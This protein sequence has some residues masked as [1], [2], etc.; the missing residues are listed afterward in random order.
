LY[1][2][3]AMT[4]ELL[5]IG[6]LSRRTGVAPELLRAWERRYGLLEPGRTPGR[7][8]LYSEADVAR[9]GSM[10]AHLDAG[11]SASEAARA[12][13]AERSRV[14]LPLLQEGAD[15]LAHALERFDDDG[16]QAALDRLLAGLSL[17]VVVREV[18]VPYLHEVGERWAR[19][20]LSVGQEHFISNVI[21]GRLLALA[22]GWDRGP[23]ARAVLASA[24]GDEHDLP[25]LLF[26]VVLRTHG[27]RIT[28]LGANT[29]VAS[30]AETVRVV[31]PDVVVVVG[32]VR[33]ILEPL[34]T[35]LREIARDARLYLAGAASNDDLAR[36]TGATHLGGDLVAATWNVVLGE[37]H[38]VY[39][40]APPRGEQ[41]RPGAQES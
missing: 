17:D 18:L 38:A 28:F 37:Q 1:K 6:E 30:L 23:G 3:R 39:S 2:F 22:R 11:L 19:G 27:W 12:T 41:Q 8:R 25:A 24:E 9:I 26:G 29:P 21:R 5:R 36:R 14:D 31:R 35:R 33:G 7:F 10:R 15:E 4:E 16:G 40:P 13:L 32:T 34:V 20:E